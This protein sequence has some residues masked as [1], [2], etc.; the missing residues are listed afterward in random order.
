MEN[1][2]ELDEIDRQL[3]A[4]LQDDASRPVKWLADQLGISISSVHRRREALRDKGVI[5][6]FTVEV[7]PGSAGRPTLF[8]V[9]VLLERETVSAVEQFKR[10][11]RTCHD[12]LQ[13]YH[14]T[15]DR[16]FVLLVA[17]RESADFPRF[18]AWLCADG[19]ETLRIRTSLV[20]DQVKPDFKSRAP[21]RRLTV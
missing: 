18:A 9:E 16:T 15:G 20:M 17:L 5:R 12:V 19:S 6:R 3:I 11:M 10:R 7:D 2:V 21:R 14:V 8:L 1:A 13:C 4:L